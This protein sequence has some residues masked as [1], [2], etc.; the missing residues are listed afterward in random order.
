M[1]TLPQ[2]YT[3]YLGLYKNNG[4]F[5]D[6]TSAFNS[7][8]AS[9]K[10]DSDSLFNIYSMTGFDYGENGGAKISVNNQQP[11]IFYYFWNNPDNIEFSRD[12]IKNYILGIQSG[13]SGQQNFNLANIF[14]TYILSFLFSTAQFNTSGNSTSFA[15][16]LLKPENNQPAIENIKNFIQSL[17][18]LSENNLLGVGNFEIPK[19]GNTTYTPTP[20]SG[21]I[22]YLCQEQFELYK[23]QNSDLTG[24]KLINSYRNNI[25]QNKFLLSFCGCYAPVPKFFHSNIKGF[26]QNPGESPCDP[27]CYNNQTFKLYN[28]SISSDKKIEGGGVIKEC[29]A[30]ICVIGNNSINSLNSNREINFNQSCKGCLEK[31]A[32]CLCFLDVSTKGLVNKISSGEKGM[33]SQARYQQNCPGNSVCFKYDD[34][35]IQEVDCNKENTPS[36]GSLFEAFKDGLT[37]VTNPEYIPDFFWFF[38]M[39]IF[40]LLFMLIYDIS[41]Y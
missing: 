6:F 40:F 13:Q 32:S 12:L 26:S 2:N 17:N 5:G 8:K 15:P 39:I 27:L 33:N 3:S 11:Y 9:Y 7:I 20:N 25:G 21:F 14:V 22:K 30:Q 18:N 38:V 23:K 16:D 35:E 36:T 31:S 34:G 29:N 4:F 1:T 19:V 37:K 24:E 41:S 28:L 10:N